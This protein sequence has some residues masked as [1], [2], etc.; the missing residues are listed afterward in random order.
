M[1]S[2]VGT[3]GVVLPIAMGAAGGVVLVLRAAGG[4]VCAGCMC[5]MAPR[6]GWPT[7]AAGGGV[8]AWTYAPVGGKVMAAVG[9]TM[10]GRSEPPV[11]KMPLA[12]WV[13]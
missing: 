5:T 13:G 9:A 6:T 7:M 4:S 11:A 1:S 8:P 3:G 10:V 2:R 12:V